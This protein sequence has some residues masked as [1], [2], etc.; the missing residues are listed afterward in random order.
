MFLCHEPWGHH[1]FEFD[2]GGRLVRERL[3]P[4]GGSLSAARAGA[5][6]TLVLR[7]NLNKI[8]LPGPAFNDACIKSLKETGHNFRENWYSTVTSLFS[9][10]Q[11]GLVNLTCR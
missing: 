6:Y 4:P 8:S 2:E 5:S 9:I 11:V 7:M 1:F 3:A 10:L